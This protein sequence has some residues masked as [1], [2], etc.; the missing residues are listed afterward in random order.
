MAG[1]SHQDIQGSINSAIKMQLA[2]LDVSVNYWQTAFNQSVAY[3]ELW[4]QTLQSVQAGEPQYANNVQRFVSLGIRSTTEFGKLAVDFTNVLI[5]ITGDS[6]TAR[7]DS[8][9]PANR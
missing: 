8:T 3:T 5:E 4:S 2:L 1:T 7:T 6:A 9:P